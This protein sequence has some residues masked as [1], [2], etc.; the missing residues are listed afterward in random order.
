[1][2]RETEEEE[3]SSLPNPLAVSPLAF[4]AL[5]LVRKSP[6]ESLLAG[7]N[8]PNLTKTADPN[9]RRISSQGL[10]KFSKQ[11]KLTRVISTPG[12][13]SP[14]FIFVFSFDT[15]VCYILLDERYFDRKMLK[16]ELS[17]V[18]KFFPTDVT[19][20][21]VNQLSKVPLRLIDTVSLLTLFFRCEV[22]R[23]VTV[24]SLV[25]KYL[26]LH[27]TAG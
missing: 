21:P 19:G 6:K 3:V 12:Y 18:P 15:L 14:L 24:S 4:N 20:T 13:S 23:H 1:M 11:F 17:R 25:L 2:G 9:R 8:Q 26:P 7:Y 22:Y 5:P 10:V 16:R 27:M